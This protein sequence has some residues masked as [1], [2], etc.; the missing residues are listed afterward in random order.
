MIKITEECNGK[1]FHFFLLSVSLGIIAGNTF[2]KDFSFSTSSEYNKD[3]A[4]CLRLLGVSR[5]TNGKRVLSE[6]YEF[7]FLTV[8]GWKDIFEIDVAI[9]QGLTL[10]FQ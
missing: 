9:T 6:F 2:L 5:H 1:C 10:R 3:Q 4:N 8:L 7:F